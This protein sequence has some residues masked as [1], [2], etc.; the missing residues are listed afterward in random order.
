MICFFEAC[1]ENI[2]KKLFFYFNLPFIFLSIFIICKDNEYRV[3]SEIDK[4]IIESRKDR[5]VPNVPFYSENYIKNGDVFEIG[6]ENDI[7]EVFRNY[8][9]YEARYDKNKRV[10]E[11]RAYEKGKLIWMEKYYYDESSDKLIQKEVFN[12]YDSNKKPIVKTF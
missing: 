12:P 2:M 9:F 10:K 4:K 8:E 6:Y 5:L 7:E 3:L 1:F 11:F